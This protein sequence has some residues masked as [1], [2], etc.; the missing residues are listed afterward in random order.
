MAEALAWTGCEVRSMCTS[1]CEGAQTMDHLGPALQRA[2]QS[3]PTSCSAGDWLRFADRGVIHEVLLTEP[4]RR[5][6]WVHDWGAAFDARYLAVLRDF[7]PQ[8]VLTFGGDASDRQRWAWARERGAVVVFVLHNLAYAKQARPAVDAVWAPSRFVADHYRA[9]WINPPDVVPTPLGDYLLASEPRQ[10]LF[11]TFINPEPAKGSAVVAGLLG[12]WVNH[13]AGQPLLI[14]E[15]RA[16]A[17]QWL[18]ALQRAGL[19]AAH[20]AQAFVSPPQEDLSTIWASTRV[21]LMPSVVDEAAG[22][23]ALEAM[24]NGVV[25]LVS[26]RGALPDTVRHADWVVPLDAAMRWDAA[27]VAS[28]QVV[29]RWD[30]ALA[31][32]L[33]DES[34]WAEA[35]DRAIRVARSHLFESVAPIYL[36]TLARVLARHP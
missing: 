35:S 34:A 14:V 36:T 18:S 10:R 16:K 13:R 15:G 2:V 8:V 21:L 11:A 29:Q 27:D 26:N 5:H 22:R 32:W 25:P 9:A 30:E 33:D 20:C 28:P 23:V 17:A 12:R 6:H 1:G 3:L 31:P 24:L 4:A 19:D 7:K